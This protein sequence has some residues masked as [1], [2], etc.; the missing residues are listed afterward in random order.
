M[1]PHTVTGL[2]SPVD[3]S[4]VVRVQVLPLVA[5]RHRAHIVNGFAYNVSVDNTWDIAAEGVPHI[6][7]MSLMDCGLQLHVPM[8]LNVRH[9]FVPNADL[10]R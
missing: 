9:A 3:Y 1:T 10:E 4:M 2:Y 7:C 5:R 6:L 8:H